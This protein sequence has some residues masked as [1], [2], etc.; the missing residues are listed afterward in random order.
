MSTSTT[1]P[2]GGHPGDRLDGVYND[3]L[4]RIMVVMREHY[5]KVLASNRFFEEET[6]IHN[7]L[8]ANNLNDALSHLGTL[9]EQAH[10]MT[11]AQQGHEVHD[12]EGHLRRGMMESYEQVFRLRMGQVEKLWREHERVVRPK[13]VEGKLRGAPPL[14]HL[15]VLRR[16]CKSLLDQ[17]RAAKR[18]HNWEAW[19]EGTEALAEACSTAT[20]LANALE[21]GIGAARGSA[22]ST[23]R[24]WGSLITGIVVAAICLPL[25]AL[26]ANWMGDGSTTVPSV[27]GKTSPSALLTLADA[28]LRI[29]INP[30]SATTR[31]C[32][33]LTQRPRAGREVSKGTVVALSA[34]CR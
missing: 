24:H 28:E 5:P 25:G 33:V 27:V 30:E 3:H 17:G 23:R 32:R 16:R 12:F 15:D 22:V 6:G 14:D 20:Q 31:R 10:L 9:F 21:Q 1:N 4:S 2:S 13:Q 29:R 19:Y 34:R 18:G 8:G 7:E 11:H 26:F